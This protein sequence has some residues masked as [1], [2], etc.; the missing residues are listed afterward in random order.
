MAIRG[1]RDE[2]IAAVAGR[3]R[4]RISRA[5]LLAAGVASRTIY[6]LLARGALIRR[7]RG[8]YAVGHAASVELGPETEALLACGPGA[9]L[10]HLTAAR[11]L[12]ILRNEPPDAPIHVTI[13]GRHGPAPDGVIVHR[14]NHL[15]DEDIREREGLPVTSPA[16]TLLDS[17]ERLSQTE[18][19]WSVDEAIQQGLVSAG[20]LARV[21]AAAPGRHGASKLQ[22]AA[23]RHANTGITRSEAEK[24]FRA[25]IADSGLPMPE[26]DHLMLGYRY[27]AY[28]PEY[29]LVVEIDSGQWHSIQ[30]KVEHDTA[31][32]AAAVA[33]GLTLIRFTAAQIKHQ[34]LVVLARAAQAIA[35]AEARAA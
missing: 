21:A 7:H 33:A 28:W 35:H 23:A 27:D 18:L 30:P 24:W 3:Q 29:R 8:V 16:R 2:R 22:K 32:G 34:P 13:A 4:G 14:T 20:I 12:H 19:D 25:L 9:V 5:Q 10:S 11:L 6:D 15:P 26:F 31:K 17:A 1:T